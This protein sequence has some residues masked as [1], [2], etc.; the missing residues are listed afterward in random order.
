MAK[1]NK[2]ND[3]TKEVIHLLVTSLCNRNCKYCCNKQYDLGQIPY[4]TDE[5]LDA[6][7]TICI[8]GG[9]PFMFTDPC[10]IAFYYKSRFHNIENVYA[11]T[12]ALELGLYLSDH[13]LSSLTGLS[14]SIKTKSDLS[15][16]EQHIVDNEEVVAMS[17]NFLYVFDNLTPKKLGNFKLFKRE[18]QEE[19]EPATDSIFRRV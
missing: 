10:K 15:A 4:V 7:K 2:R 18:W 8:T 6:C 14:V 17:S 19:F 12:N 9:E 16:F 11:Y 13:H 3:K 5:E 1:L